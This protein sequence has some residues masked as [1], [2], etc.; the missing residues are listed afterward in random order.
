MVE[1]LDHTRKT[2]EF[3]PAQPYPP[4]DMIAPTSRSNV[5]IR[6][7]VAA[8]R[9]AYNAFL[10]AAVQAH[11]DT[12]RIAASDVASAPFDTEPADATVTFA[13]AAA[14]GAWM[15]VVSIERERGRVKR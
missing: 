3:S 9:A 8:D 10:T 1:P 4:R 5:A 2:R 6:P 13:A 12:L 7:L 15:G 14:D 11:P